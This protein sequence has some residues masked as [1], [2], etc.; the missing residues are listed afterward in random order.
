MWLIAWKKYEHSA[1]AT[2]VSMMGNIVIL[3]GAIGLGILTAQLNGVLGIVVGIAGYVGL[4]IGLN[5]LTDH[6]AKADVK[7]SVE[8]YHRKSVR[9]EAAQQD[10]DAVLMQAMAEETDP[11]KLYKAIYDSF[12]QSIIHSKI[13]NEMRFQAAQRLDDEHLK[14]LIDTS[15]GYFNYNRSLQKRCL[16]KGEPVNEVTVRNMTR[17]IGMVRDPAEREALMKYYYLSK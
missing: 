16:E 6:I 15:K 14:K 11:D 9:E 3:F 5:K 12:R 2:G 4:R 17:L 10:K 8:R 13:N 1:I 7:A